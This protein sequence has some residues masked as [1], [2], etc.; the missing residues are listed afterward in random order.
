MPATGIAGVPIAVQIDK[1]AV[2]ISVTGVI[3]T[4]AAVAINVIAIICIAVVPFI[5]TVIPVGKTKLVMSFEQ[6]SSSVQVFVLSGNVAAD[7]FVAALKKFAMK[8][9]PSEDMVD[10]Q[11]VSTGM[12]SQMFEIEI[13]HISG[14]EV[15][16]S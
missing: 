2:S 13:E 10:D 9:Y 16:E 14:K 12:A 15:Q 8:Y 4:P 11:I 1:K 6:P 3:S 5:L 7:E